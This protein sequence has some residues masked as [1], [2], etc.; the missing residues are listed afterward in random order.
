MRLL[1]TGAGG[2]L[3]IDLVGWCESA[4]DDVVATSHADL[5]IADRDAVHGAVSVLRPDAVVNCAA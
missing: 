2:Q 1:I 4:G 3:G 5:D